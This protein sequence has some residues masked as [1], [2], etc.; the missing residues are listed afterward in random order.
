L[1][2][3]IDTSAIYAG[4]AAGDEFHTAAVRSWAGLFERRESLLTH[5]LV[6]VEAAALLQTRL[7]V[8]AV[9]AMSD[10]LLP[11]IQVVEI[12]R[13]GRRAALAAL[14]ADRRREVSLVDRVS[15]SLMRARGVDTAFTFD[16]HFAEA[17]FDLI[18]SRG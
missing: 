8:E 6:E 2:I 7:G 15:F 5:S 16:R 4:I 17:G 10:A 9:E 13:A 18:G 12:D 14:A 1:S 11:Q 3:F